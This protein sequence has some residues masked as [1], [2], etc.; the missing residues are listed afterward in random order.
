VAEY[1]EQ[2][3]DESRDGRKEGNWC[4]HFVCQLHIRMSVAE[5]PVQKKEKAKKGHRE[6]ETDHA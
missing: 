3:D 5:P 2:A 4:G 6:K 1:S